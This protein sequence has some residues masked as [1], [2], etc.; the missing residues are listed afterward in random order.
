MLLAAEPELVDD[1]DG[2]RRRRWA[3][4]APVVAS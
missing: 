4:L 3:A 1:P 2:E